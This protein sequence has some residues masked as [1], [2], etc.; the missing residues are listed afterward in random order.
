MTEVLALQDKVAGM[1]ELA[2]TRGLRA[3]V[4]QHA[5]PKA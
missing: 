2:M 1:P 5:V 4:R 3:W